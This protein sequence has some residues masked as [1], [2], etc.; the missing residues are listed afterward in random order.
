VPANHGHLVPLDEI[1]DGRIGYTR[2][3]AYVEGLDDD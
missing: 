3:T 2:A 1:T